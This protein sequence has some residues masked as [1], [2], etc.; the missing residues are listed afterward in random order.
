MIAIE[1]LRKRGLRACYVD[2]DCHHGDGVQAAYYDT[3]AV[4]T[5]S[6]HESVRYL[7]PGTG[8]A[9]EAGGKGRGYSVNVPLASYT[10]DEVFAWAFNQVVPPLVQAFKPDVLVTQ[11]GIDTHFNDPIT[12]LQ[13]TVEGY[14][15]VVRALGLLAPKWVV[16]GG[17]GYDI[18]ALARGWSLDYGIMMGVHWPDAIPQEYQRAYGLASLRDGAAPVLSAEVLARTRSFAE[19]SVSKVRELVFPHHGIG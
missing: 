16:L 5:I 14:R 4:I 10:G 6:L 9:E 13:M 17:G 19:A 18:S 15:A 12:H 1:Y 2:I 8:E 11:L 3:D 7:F